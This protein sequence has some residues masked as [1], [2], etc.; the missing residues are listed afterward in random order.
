[1]VGTNIIEN[2]THL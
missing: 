2:D 1:M